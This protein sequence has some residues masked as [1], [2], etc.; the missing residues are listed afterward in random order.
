MA[1]VAS[2]R[3]VI[4]FVKTVEAGN[5]VGA[6][7]ELG[8]SP[9]AVSKNVQRLEHQLGV[10]LL[11]RSTRKLNLT[12]EGHLFYERCT[13]PLRELEGA[14]SA[15]KDKRRSLSGALRITS[16][17]PFGRTYVLPL[18]SAFS[19]KYPNIEVELHL[20]D[21]VSD[22]IAQGYDVGIRAGNVK[23]GNMVVR[24]IAPLYFVACGAPAYLR[25]HG[26]PK[27]PADLAHH[28]CLRL[29]RQTN[30]DKALNWSL[31]P[32]RTATSPPVRGNL[33]SNDVTTL[34][35]AAVNGHGLV[36]APLPL[37]LPLF[38]SGMLIPVLPEYISKPAYVFIHYP[39]RKHLPA[40]V[41]SFVNFMLDNLRAN[42]DL[43]SDPRT[44]L[45][46]FLG[47]TRMSAKKK[48]PK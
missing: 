7:K 19:Q 2:I 1:G 21:T 45:A 46:P 41:Q 26:T 44:L 34:V 30:A 4:S 22:M 37:V 36:F 3:G 33:V 5:F 24:E 13:G 12:E 14:H 8:I 18:L 32:D 42:P 20:D 27:K 40:R 43:T 23:D 17:A 29:R 6:A 39:N 15:V 16:I 38:R 47:T 9:V 35:M 48:K 31:G 25:Q 11:R 10:R 28:N